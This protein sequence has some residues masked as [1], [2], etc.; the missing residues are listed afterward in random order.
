MTLTGVG[1]VGKTRLALQVAAEVVTDFPDGAWL[2]EFAPVADPDAVW[3]TLGGVVCGC[4]PSR[5]G[6][7][8]SRCSSTWRRSG[9][10]WCSTTVSTSST[11]S[12]ARSTRSPNAAPACRC[13]RRA[14]KGSRSPGERIVAVPSLGVPAD[15]ADVDALMARGRGA[16]VLG[17]GAAP[18]RTTSRSPTATRA[19]SACCA[20]GSTGSRWRSSSPRRGCGRCHP[21][22]SLPVSI[23]G[24]SS[25]PGG[26]APRSSGIRRC[27]ARSTGPT[28]CSNR[29]N[30][31]RWTACR[32]S[33]A[34]VIWPRPKPC[35]PATTSTRSDVVDVLG[36]LVD[37]SLV[38]ADDNADGG[39]RYRLLESIRQY[40]PGATRS[41]RRHRRGPAPPRR[42]LRRRSPRPPAR[43]C[44]A[45]TSSSG[46]RSSHRDI[47]NF[48][49][50]F[51]WA[52]ETPSPDHA[53]RL[54]APFTRDGMAIG[55]AAQ[56]WAETASTIPGGD[57]H[58]LFPV[59]AAWASLG[60][61]LQRRLR[62]SRSTR[63]R[64]GTGS[65]GARRPADRRVANARAVLAFF[66]GDLEQVAQHA[67]EWASS[68]GRPAT[69]TSSRTALTLL[70]AASPAR[71][72]R[73]DR[74]RSRSRC[75]SPA[76]RGSASALSIGLPFL[77]GMLP[78]EESERALALLDEAIEVGDEI[79]DRLGV[80]RRPAS[81]GDRRPP[82]RVADGPAGGGRHGRATAPARRPPQPPPV[83]TVRR[84]RVLR[85]R[86]PRR[87]GDAHRQGRRALRSEERAGLDPRDARDHA[88]PCSSKA[89]VPSRSRY[90]RREVRRS[91][92][93]R[94]S[95]TCAPKRSRY[96]RPSARSVTW[97]VLGREGNGAV[98]IVGIALELRGAGGV[99]GVGFAWRPATIAQVP[100]IACGGP[101]TGGAPRSR[102]SRLLARAVHAGV[103]AGVG[104]WLA[105]ELVVDSAS[106]LIPRRW[107]RRDTSP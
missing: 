56:D 48:R 11:R 73:R 94:P 60:R 54:V 51:D 1:G 67:Q 14:G 13:S 61:H 78:I 92:P 70:A 44:G 17:S 43:T 58:P 10:C 84:R 15:D 31:A 25:S 91:T 38:V 88:M 26:A 24:S 2:C 22:I 39:V 101:A 19:R 18:R 72:R 104:A 82:R 37:K 36:Q 102:R 69:T 62:T 28:T 106:R 96:S 57:D 100:C 98:A 46:P 105:V 41:R 107:R 3:E 76:T 4:R 86:K 63:R 20:G 66:R 71:A 97:S 83:V 9:C 85:V 27:G 59:V 81:R 7:S 87:R 29:P 30:V 5:A 90:S 32:S 12:P 65:S 80:W 45:E 103:D 6:A 89:S 79:G 34:A 23:S 68:R 8:R 99:D 95:L 33:P 53:F 21:R 35:W 77:A 55:D 74:D 47:D 40:A 49:A 64:R 75:A 93:P 42:P 16:A 50:A 52:V